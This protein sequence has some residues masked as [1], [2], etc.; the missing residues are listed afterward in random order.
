MPSQGEDRSGSSGPGRGESV[1]RPAI[2]SLPWAVLTEAPD[3]RVRA[4]NRAFCEAFD[5]ADE[6][7]AL[8]GLSAEAVWQRAAAATADASGFLA[9]MRAHAAERRS[10]TREPVVLG[11]GRTLLRDSVP[12]RGADGAL[13]LHAWLFADVTQEMREAEERQQVRNLESVGRLAAAVAHDLNN[14]LTAVMGHASLL[15]MELEGEAE[16]ME[17]VREILRG[18]Q[19]A[20]ALT[21]RLLAFGRR[22]LLQ[23]RLTD[24]VTVVRRVEEVLSR[25]LGPKVELELRLPEE[26]AALRVDEQKLE[27]AL[28][29]VANN[30]RDAMMPDGGRL[31]LELTYGLLPERR[32]SA[33]AV[34]SD[35][36]WAVFSVVDTGPGI[37]EEIRAHV[38][39]PFFSTKARHEG[40]GL[41]LAA[42]KGFVDQSGGLVWIEDGSGGTTVRMALPLATASDALGAE[43]ENDAPR[44]EQSSSAATILVAEDE[45]SV[46]TLL[47]RTLE[48]GGHTVLTAPDGVEALRVLDLH[49]R[50]VDLLVTDV[51]MPR[52]DGLELARRVR[53]RIPGVPIL[54]ASGFPADV[55]RG[56]D[57]PLAGARLLEKPFLASDVLRAVDE[58]LGR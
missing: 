5:L 39:E 37:P 53:E 45:P 41:G 30:A 28:L 43:A 20:G 56:M 8:E 14:A 52:M 27:S 54:L 38:F 2:E 40:A 23:P 13:V 22:Q 7:E 21:R 3:G 29:D 46:M 18:A 24:P 26:Q 31:L 16:R 17:S 44:A 49:G 19:R 1:P 12:M 33:A 10:A 50:D 4:A 51:T 34:H 9:E 42:V 58:M 32:R 57:V 35:R 25:M 11:D 48:D 36:R 55:V 47:R 15:E 6:P